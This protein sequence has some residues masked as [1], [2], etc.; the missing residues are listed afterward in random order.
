ME[1]SPLSRTTRL[2]TTLVAL[3]LLAQH[4]ARAQATPQSEQTVG[5]QQSQD[6]MA[7]AGPHKAEFD[8][9]HRPI[10]AGGFV[11]SGPVIFMHVA[12]SAGLT[13]WYRTSGTPEKRLILEAK[14]AGVCLLDY[15]N[16]GWL[17]IYVTNNGKNRLYHNYH[18]G[19]FTDVAETA[20]VTVEVAADAWLLD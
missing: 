16:D 3:T 20:G 14:G 11:K 2:L 5:R 13:S 7:N 9:E 8:S 6:G 18:D 1:R 12:K 10:T 19:T 4:L 15:D 17:D